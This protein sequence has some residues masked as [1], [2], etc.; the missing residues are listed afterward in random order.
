VA[1]RQAERQVQQREEEERREHGRREAEDATA[2]HR[3][4]LEAERVARQQ[5]AQDRLE[6]EL[7]A[8]RLRLER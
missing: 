5:L 7:S 4:G 8:D 1:E 3:A 6:N 2:R